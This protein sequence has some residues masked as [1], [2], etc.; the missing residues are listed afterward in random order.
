MNYVM[1]L[2]ENLFT[3]KR[4]ALGRYFKKAHKQLIFETIPKLMKK[5][6]QDGVYEVE[7][8]AEELFKKVYG[9]ITMKFSVKKDVAIIEDIVPDNIL[10]A[11]YMK[12]LPLYKGIPFE[13]KNDLKKIKMMEA[14]LC[15][16]GKKN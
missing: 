7:L 12:D 14:I 6:K 3:K 13:T 16:T 9:P 5:G 11:C 15:Q 1:Y 4:K 10:M 8:E 2:D